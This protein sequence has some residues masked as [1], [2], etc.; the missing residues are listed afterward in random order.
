MYPQPPRRPPQCRVVAG[1]LSRVPPWGVMEGN[2]VG[3]CNSAK[4]VVR[5]AFIIPP[6]TNLSR[7]N[8]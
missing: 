4:I 6:D 1:G 2:L 3:I 8:G 7:I 5:I